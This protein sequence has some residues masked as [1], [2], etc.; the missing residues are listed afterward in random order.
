MK[1]SII[2]PVYNECNT[3]EKILNKVNEL[4]IDKEIIVVDDLSTDGTR[5]ILKKITKENVDIL[6]HDKNRGKGAALRTGISHAAG[7]IIIIQDA[8]LEYDPNEIPRVI[9]PIINGKADVVYGSRFMANRPDLIISWQSKLANKFLTLLTNILFGKA[10]TDMETCY[11]AFRAGVIRSI[12]LETDRFGVDPEITCKVIKKGIDIFEVPI[13]FEARKWSEGKKIG[14]KD[15]IEAILL[16][17]KYR[18]S[19]D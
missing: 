11:K 6:Y 4:P 17:I 1:T 16:L 18:F 2:M 12:R 3:I 14:L 7:D 15:G 19:K 13:S 5:D 9:D 8:D 10:L